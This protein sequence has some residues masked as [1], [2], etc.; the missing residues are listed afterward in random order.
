ML[1]SLAG[2]TCSCKSTYAEVRDFRQEQQQHAEEQPEE[3]LDPWL[4][5]RDEM[6]FADALEDTL[7]FNAD[8]M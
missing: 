5:T 8:F 2:V 7:E 3:E 1:G 6:K 4:L